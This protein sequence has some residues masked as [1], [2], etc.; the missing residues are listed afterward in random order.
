MKTWPTNSTSYGRR[1]GKSNF[2]LASFVVV[3]VFALV[4]VGVLVA[5]G[6]LNFVA[7]GIRGG[8][9]ELAIRAWDRPVMDMIDAGIPDT[10]VFRRRI[11]SP[12]PSRRQT[13]QWVP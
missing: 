3:V 12:L 13:W 11:G 6:W 5:C 4:V 2:L 8:R 9:E 7:V 1:D 10:P